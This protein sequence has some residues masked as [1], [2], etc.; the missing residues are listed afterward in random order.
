MN[1][2]KLW[3]YLSVDYWYNVESLSIFFWI[4]D[5]EVIALSK[6]DGIGSLLFVA[7]GN[8]GYIGSVSERAL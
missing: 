2:S 4:E 8:I 7:R 5:V 3:F 1:K 6:V